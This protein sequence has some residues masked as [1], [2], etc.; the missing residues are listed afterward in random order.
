MYHNVKKIS[1]LLFSA[2]L[3][4]LIS[5][6]AHSNETVWTQSLKLE[7]QKNYEQAA[8]VLTPLIENN[9]DEYALLR[10]AYLS[11]MQGEFNDS[12]SQYLEAI[13]LNPKSID[14]R[15]GVTLPLIAQRR[16]R[17]VK[18]YT[19]EVLRQSHWNY[20]AHI[21]LLIAEEGMRNWKDLASHAKQI[22]EIYPSD[23]TALVYLARANIWLSNTRAAINAYKEVLKR[24]PAHIEARQFIAVNK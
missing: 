21:R 10:S 9:S 20:T 23:A 8:V 15:L 18:R 12:I 24:S 16:W 3:L 14:A 6:S 22:A 17:Q 13:D 19:Y 4:L 2:I 1:S 11:Y 5:S 7:A